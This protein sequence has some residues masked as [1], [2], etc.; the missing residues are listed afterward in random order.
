M[1]RVRSATQN[2][3]V[4]RGNAET[5]GNR[6]LTLRHYDRSRP[7][8]P[9][10][11]CRTLHEYARACSAKLNTMPAPPCRLGRLGQLKGNMFRLV[12]RGISRGDIGLIGACCMLH[13]AC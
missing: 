1:A 12:L 3:N 10:L 9:I 6:F 4:K 2:R 5:N 7:P 13:V 8:T 11:I